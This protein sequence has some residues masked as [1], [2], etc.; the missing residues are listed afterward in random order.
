VF[1][2]QVLVQLAVQNTFRQRLLQVVKQP[3]LAENLV[4]ITVPKQLVQKLLVD[5]HAMILLLSSS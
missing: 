1:G 2:L 4:R 3:V 5:S